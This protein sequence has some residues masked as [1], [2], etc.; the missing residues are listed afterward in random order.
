MK[1]RM[2]WPLIG[3]LVLLLAAAFGYGYGVGYEEAWA[4]PC[5]CLVY[6]CPEGGEKCWGVIYPT[7][8]YPNFQE[9]PCQAC[10]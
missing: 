2:R 3:A 10:P 4:A 7:G 9:C 1:S 6:T 8:C 5:P